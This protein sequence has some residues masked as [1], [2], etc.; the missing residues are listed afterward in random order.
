[1]N[2]LSQEDKKRYKEQPHLFKLHYLYREYKLDFKPLERKYTLPNIRD[3]S[4]LYVSP[5]TLGLILTHHVNFGLSTRMTAALMR[6][7]HG[8]NISHA[9]VNNYA[10]AAA[11]IV[12]PFV[13]NFDY[14]PSNTLCGDETY[15]KVLG[16][17]HYVYFILDA[18]KK[19]S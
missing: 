2:S 3:I 5:H 8:V 16:K 12:K 15:I 4:K 18:V 19:S 10:N 9:S 17:W 11:L 7:V 13:D 14:K 6:E 1:M